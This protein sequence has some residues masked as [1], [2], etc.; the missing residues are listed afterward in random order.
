MHASFKVVTK[1]LRMKESKQ[2][3]YSVLTFTDDEEL[4]RFDTLN[5]IMKKETIKDSHVCR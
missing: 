2:I 4:A 1:V 3:A 5:K